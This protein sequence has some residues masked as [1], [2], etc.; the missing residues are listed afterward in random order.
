MM[1]SKGEFNDNDYQEHYRLNYSGSGHT[2]MHVRPAYRYGYEM[3]KD[4]RYQ[5]RNWNEPTEREL[6]RAWDSRG[7]AMRW[8]D[9]RTAI[10]EGWNRAKGVSKP[11]ALGSSTYDLNLRDIEG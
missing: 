7:A 10:R 11:R 9:A 8:D 6:R 3:A 1:A 5:G 2:Y 4:A